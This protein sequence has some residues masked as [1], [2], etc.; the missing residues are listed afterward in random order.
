MREHP[1]MEKSKKCRKIEKNKIKVFV[2][3]YWVLTFQVS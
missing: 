3:K 2:Q 1:V